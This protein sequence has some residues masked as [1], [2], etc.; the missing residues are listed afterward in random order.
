MNA[1]FVLQACG[2]HKSYHKNK[3][4][5]PVLRGI[6]VNITAGK[7]NALIGRSGSGKSTLMHLLATLDRPDTGEIMFQGKRIDDA[8]RAAR[9]AYRNQDIGIIFQFYH[10][11]PELTALENVLAPIMIRQ[12]LWGYFRNR[13]EI[14]K[15]AEAMLDR[16]GLSHRATHRPAEMSG[17]EMQRA[18]IARALMT[19]PSL[20]LA[21][22]PTGNLDTETGESILKL[23][24][25]LNQ[26]DHL[27]IVMITHDD[28]IAEKADVCYRMQ[29]G[30]LETTHCAR[31]AA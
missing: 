24:V 31:H 7:I 22:E 29:D 14:R 5:V 16:V 3:I 8:P 25:E 1:E 4:E 13:K 10:L 2:I 27:T 20:L 15:R 9:D 19:D 26:Q 21:D 28:A 18:A 23:L 12:S 11:L 30:L 6:D 17:G